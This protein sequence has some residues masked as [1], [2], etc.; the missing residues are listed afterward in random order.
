M[1]NRMEIEMTSVQDGERQVV[2]GGDEMENDAEEEIQEEKV[3]VE[4]DAPGVRSSI[5][6]IRRYIKHASA[7]D[8]AKQLLD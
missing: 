5:S 7:N 6:R 8:L 2:A 3:K 1:A 4:E